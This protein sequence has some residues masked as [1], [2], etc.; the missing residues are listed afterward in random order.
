MENLV[1]MQFFAW[2]PFRGA[3]EGGG[4]AGQ[5]GRMRGAVRRPA[6]L[7]S[8]ERPHRGRWG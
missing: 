5:P 3:E 7:E 6:D 2:G 4:R 8:P 1:K